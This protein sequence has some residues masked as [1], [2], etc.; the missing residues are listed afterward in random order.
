METLTL[1]SLRFRGYHGHYEQEREQGNDF[2]V[3]LVFSG[4]LRAAGES[5]ELGDTID[6]QQAQEIARSVMEGP[7]VKLIETLAKRIGDQI[8]EAIPQAKTLEVTVRKLQPP[9][10]IKTAYSEI[11]MQWQR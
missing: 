9:L 1:K 4:E 7:S 5:D 3:D 6:Y 8:F 2:E 10:D 11:R